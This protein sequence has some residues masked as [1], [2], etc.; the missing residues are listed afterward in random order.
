[1]QANRAKVFVLPNVQPVQ[2]TEKHSRFLLAPSSAF[3]ITRTALK[4]G[5]P[6]LVNVNIKLHFQ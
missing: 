5:S 2:T 3:K 6:S 4:S 1:M